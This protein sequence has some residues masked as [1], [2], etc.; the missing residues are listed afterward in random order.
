MNCSDRGLKYNPGLFL[1]I[2][3]PPQQLSERRPKF[4][5]ELTKI[6]KRIIWFQTTL[7]KGKSLNTKRLAYHAALASFLF[8]CFIYSLL[9]TLKDWG[10]LN[11][12]LSCIFGTVC[13][14]Y[15][16]KTIYV[17]VFEAI[18]DAKLSEKK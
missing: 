2:H 18:R 14:F 7:T 4:G 12:M 6:I 5:A 17:V 10:F 8:G 9:L 11:G 15:T 1:F 16:F 3:P 13:L